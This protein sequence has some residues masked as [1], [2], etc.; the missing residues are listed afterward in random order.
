MLAATHASGEFRWLT[1]KEIA[2]RAVG[3]APPTVT[4]LVNRLAGYGWL[5]TH[6]A[7][8]RLRQFRFHEA[9]ARA[10]RAALGM[11]PPAPLVDPP[12]EPA[13]PAPNFNAP[14]GRYK[15]MTA[16][17]ATESPETLAK[18]REL[19]GWGEDNRPKTPK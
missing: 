1:V 19:M 8:G 6:L 18:V 17:A 12:P 9:G 11:Q 2:G 15:S 7:T 5:E 14:A 10:A 13:A 4:T 3:L 16:L